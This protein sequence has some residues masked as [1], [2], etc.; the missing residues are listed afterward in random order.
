LDKAGL[1]KLKPESGLTSRV[2]DIAENPRN[3][4]IIEIE[5]A[6][7]PRV[8]DDSKVVIALINNNYAASAGLLLKDGLFTED[9]DSYY[10]NII[11]ARE[12]NKDDEKVKKF[13]QAYQSDEVAEAAEREFKGGAIKGW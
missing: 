3:F 9:K 12:D 5:A 6:Q 1:I 4:K 7:L 10:V 2:I 11:V 8:L 13:V